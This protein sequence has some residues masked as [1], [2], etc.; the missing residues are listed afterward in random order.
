MRR[1]LLGPDN[2]TGVLVTILLLFVLAPLF[3]S[4]AQVTEI[5]FCAFLSVVI[6]TV[7]ALNFPPRHQPNKKH[8][9]QHLWLGIMLLAINLAAYLTEQS[10][11]PILAIILAALLMNVLFFSYAASAFFMRVFKSQ[12]VTLHIIG[13]AICIYLFAGI[14]WGLLYGVIEMLIPHS[15]NANIFDN[16]AHLASKG[17]LEAFLRN[18]LYF[19]FIT[20]TTLG[21]GD[22]LPLS[23]PARYLS[24]LQGIFGQIYLSVLVARLVGMHIL[25]K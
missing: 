14:I 23:M 4:H 9:S 1:H 8:G 18:H 13:G 15:F 25:Q 17:W 2:F 20:M 22:I 3:N 16:G 5:W 11:K 7:Y 6:T 24:A 21:F 12:R 19:S 10:A